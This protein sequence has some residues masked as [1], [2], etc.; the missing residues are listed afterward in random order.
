MRVFITGGTG[1][2]GRSVTRQLILRGHQV[3]L[4]ARRNIS[5]AAGADVIGG[6]L[7]EIEKV[8][9]SLKEWKADTCIHLAWYA[10]P[11][12]YLNAQ[13]NAQ[14][15]GWS[16]DLLRVLAAADCRHVVMAGTCAEYDSDNGY[17]REDGPTRPATLYAA[18]KLSLYL[19][20]QQLAR[21]QDMRL[22]WGRIFYPYGPHEDPRRAIAALINTLLL[23]QPFKATKGMQVRDYLHVD[24]I[25]RAFVSLAENGAEGC[26][27]IASGM[28]V[29]IRNL[30]E[31]VGQIIGTPELIEFGA[32]PYREWDPPFICGDNHRLRDLGW[33]P[34]YGLTDGLGSTVSWWRDRLKS[35]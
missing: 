10:E 7:S 24:D 32:L 1:F 35:A 34:E 11:G 3:A 6:D 2:I 8:K 12:K 31:T 20:G 19:T 5:G 14:F 18:S 9:S 30:M 29:T 15:L 4:L 27:N 25:A 26:F 33:T 16:L 17:L 13:M 22:A 28:P 23:G 21:Q